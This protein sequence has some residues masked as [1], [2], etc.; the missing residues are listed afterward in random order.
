M[1]IKFNNLTFKNF[2]NYGNKEA[3]IDF[4]EGRTLITGLNGNGKSTIFMALYYALY[5]KPYKKNKMLSLINNV[6]NK[7][8]LVTIEFSIN[9]VQYIV[10]RGMKPAIFEI[11]E[12]DILIHQN[13]SMTE[14]Q[15]YFETY[16]FPVPE[17]AFKQLIFLGANVIGSKTFVDLTKAEKDELFQII[18]DTSMFPLFKEGIKKRRDK[19]KTFQTELSYQKSVLEKVIENELLSISRLEHQNSQIK[20][21]NEQRLKKMSENKKEIEKEIETINSVLSQ[22]KNKKETYDAKIIEK[23]KLNKKLSEWTSDYNKAEYSLMDLEK[24]KHIPEKY[25]KCVGCQHLSNIIEVVSPE[26]LE[27]AE[28]GFQEIL[29]S[30]KEKIEKAKQ[31]LE[32]LETEITLL[33]KELIEG[34]ALK[35]KKQTLLEKLEEETEEQVLITIDKTLLETSQQEAKEIDEKLLDCNNQLTILLNLEKL[36]S[37]D[38]LKGVII[39][40]QLPILNKYINEFLS[41]FSDFSFNFYIDNTFKEN[42]ISKSKDFEFYSLS[43]GQSMRVTFSIMFAF[44]KLVEERNGITTNLLI[45]DEVLDSSLDKNGRLELLNMLDFEHKEVFVISHNE[46]ITM[47]SSFDR[48]ITVSNENGFGRIAIN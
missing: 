33:Y 30:F 16:I 36:L 25:A 41:S 34:K 22:L 24:K 11:Y 13:S 7:D 18:T 40:E 28:K 20:I 9:N 15:N 39:N 8:M 42:V 12:D 6:N 45:L 4:K 27:L 21:A 31:Q 29:T 43:N 2:M 46:D 44:L 48:T 5:G 37:N 14:Y 26:E 17:N 23:T 32:S 35:D 19:E 10:K 38:N 1:H 47:S 3:V